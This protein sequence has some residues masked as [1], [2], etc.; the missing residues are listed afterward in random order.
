MTTTT[1]FTV[2]TTSGVPA[3]PYNAT[4]AGLEAYSE[5]VEN[6]GE[7]IRPSNG[8]QQTGRSWLCGG[9]IELAFEL[10][11]SSTMKF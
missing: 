8:S 5:N 6:Y 3:G 2:S 9:R 11:L 7:G 10:T 4:F 1:Q